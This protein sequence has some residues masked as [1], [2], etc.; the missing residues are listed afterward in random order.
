M[1]NFKILISLSLDI[2][3]ERQPLEPYIF[4]DAHMKPPITRYYWPWKRCLQTVYLK[5]QWFKFKN[6]QIPR[7]SCN[8]DSFC[9]MVLL[10]VLHFYCLAIGKKKSG[11][12]YSLEA[13]KIKISATKEKKGL[14]FSIFSSPF[15]LWP[16]KKKVCPSIS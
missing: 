4:L 1:G 11:T 12:F 14:D 6:V 3:H 16:C 2:V 5:W 15:S 13:I 9:R 7:K 10:R 8:I